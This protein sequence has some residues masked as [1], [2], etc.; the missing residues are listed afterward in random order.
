MVDVY[1]S[2]SI[3]DFNRV[4]P[5]ARA[6]RDLGYTIWPDPRP[7]FNEPEVSLDERKRLLRTAKCIVAFF[8]LHSRRRVIKEAR[9]GSARKVLVCVRLDRDAEPPPGLT[10]SSVVDLN[11][12][13]WSSMFL[14]FVDDVRTLVRRGSEK[15]HE[16]PELRAPLRVDPTTAGVQP[17]ADRSS[18]KDAPVFIQRASILHFGPFASLDLPLKPGLNVVVGG[19]ASGKTSLMTALLFGL[20]GEGA[21]DVRQNKY[22]S[23]SSRVELVLCQGERRAL[24]ISEVRPQSRSIQ[25][26]VQASE[27]DEHLRSLIEKGT[28]A[29]SYSE[30]L[31]LS[32]NDPMLPKAFELLASMS[33]ELAAY[34]QPMRERKRLAEFSA[35]ATLLLAFALFCVEQEVQTYSGPLLLDEPFGGADLRTQE[36]LADLLE[37]L[38]TRRQ[39]ILFCHTPSQRLRKFIVW[40]L[41]GTFPAGSFRPPDGAREASTT[42]ERPAAEKQLA[43]L[44]PSPKQVAEAGDVRRVFVSYRHESEQHNEQVLALVQRLR[45]DGIDCRIDRF[46]MSPPEG[47]PRWSRGEIEQARYVLMVCS[48]NYHRAFEPGAQPRTG[49]GV[50]SEGAAI[51]QLLY[52]AGGRNDKFIPILLEGGLEEHIPLPL[53]GTTR[54]RMAPDYDALLR[55]LVGQPEI[56]PVP[57][58]SPPPLPPRQ[59]LP[60]ASVGAR[61]TDRPPTPSFRSENEKR[62]ADE[63]AM[64]HEKK[65]ARL[66]AGESIQAVQAEILDLRRKMREGAQLL[67]GDLLYDG[68]FKLVERIGKGGFGSVWKA[69][70]REAQELVA[71]KVLHGHLVDERS[72]LERFFRGARRMAKLS[73]PS[74]VRVF[75]EKAEEGTFHFFVMEFVRGFDLKQ[76]VLD[77]GLKAPQALSILVEVS[78][79]L[80]HAHERGLVHRDVKPANIL[81]AEDGRPK[82]TDFDLVW[83]ADTTQNTRAG[84]G[85]PVYAAPEIFATP[86]EVTPA[87]DI[88]GLAMCAVFALQGQELTPEI[89]Y[90]PVEFVDRLQCASALKGLILA[91]L[92]FNPSKRLQSAAEFGDRLAAA[93]GG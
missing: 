19:M 30:R 76:S 44:T 90:R 9:E 37:R 55:R 28:Q 87:T 34:V 88:Y 81:I 35:G 45:R 72:D 74:I 29:L 25:H 49:L 61:R 46:V 26:W 32:L 39:L 82:L 13:I 14:N 17:A 77:R 93:L 51:E 16:E 62:W 71:V 3:L 78:R 59:Q 42:H 11:L 80:A 27:G 86:G 92:E 57:L 10:S 66:I 68:R 15:N 7:G 36:I 85:T 54:Y 48:E 8:S 2:Y 56:K 60:I 69:Y 5:I 83:A 21:A 91:C 52:D 79:A 58:G 12:S 53:R 43:R 75:I 84:L 33:S 18:G 73:H 65:E 1:L 4:E 41:P 38:A 20:L 31:T 70:D 63:L 50:A 89:L 22:A 24:L 64:L 40:S 47:W 23:V 6:L 67:A